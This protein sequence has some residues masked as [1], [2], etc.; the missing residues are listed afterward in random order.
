MRACSET[1][2]A[3]RNIPPVRPGMR[4]IPPKSGLLALVVAAS[5][6]IFVLAGCGSS[7]KSTTAAPATS[8]STARASAS[9]ATATSPT[10]TTGP[11][12][13]TLRGENHAPVAGKPWSYSVRVTDPSGH[14]LEGTVET[15][16]VVQPIG[17]VGKET[18]PVHRL[19]G[20]KLNDNVTFPA[21]A[22]GHPITLATVIHTSAGS[23]ALGWSVSVSK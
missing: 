8:T 2:Q 19:K 21:E 17:V 6:A 14:P 3:G 23:V 7:K 18:P 5:L 22:V 4:R 16:F 13:A 20:G 12:R 11:V 9:P 1:N 10:V 15:D